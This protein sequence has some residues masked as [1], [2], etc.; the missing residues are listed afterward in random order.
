MMRLSRSS[1]FAI[2][3]VMAYNATLSIGAMFG[4]AK[5]LGH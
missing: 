5:L 3:S 4:L 2:I 1:R